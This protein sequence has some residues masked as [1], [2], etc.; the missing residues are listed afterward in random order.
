MSLGEHRI[1]AGSEIRPKGS[2][3]VDLVVVGEGEQTLVEALT[4]LSEDGNRREAL[5]GVNGLAF[6]EGEGAVVRTPARSHCAQLDALPLGSTQDGG[7]WAW[8][9]AVIADAPFTSYL[10]GQQTACSAR[11]CGLLVDGGSACTL[12]L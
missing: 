1:R 7:R 10:V 11:S 5:K 8:L 9:G 4:L 6:L 12:R 2:H 3:P